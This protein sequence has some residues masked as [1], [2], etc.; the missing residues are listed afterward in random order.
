M[1]KQKHVDPA[2]ELSAWFEIIN[3]DNE[4]LGSNY[5]IQDNSINWQTHLTCI[6]V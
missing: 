3:N 1:T 2:S 5:S 6:S 4:Q